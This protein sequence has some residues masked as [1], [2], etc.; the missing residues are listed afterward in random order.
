MV[1]GTTAY[2]SPEQAIGKEL[3]TRTD[4]F[5]LGVIAHE[6]LTGAR[7]FYKGNPAQEMAA[8]YEGE[9]PLPSKANRRV[10]KAV[11]PV[12]MRALE[13]KL[14]KRYQTA[15]EFTRDL[16][17]AAGST[18][19]PKERNAEM[20]RAQFAERQRDT[21]KLLARIPTRGP[22]YPEARTQITRGGSQLF[23]DG[24]MPKTLLA[25]DPLGKQGVQKPPALPEGTDSGPPHSST[26]PSREPVTDTAKA[27]EQRLTA[28]EL[29]EDFDSEETRIISGS[30][31]GLPPVEM[32]TDP[33]RLAA[34]RQPE[35]EATDADSNQVDTEERE[36]AQRRP[37]GSSSASLF[38]AAVLA[39]ILGEIGRASCRERVS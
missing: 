30:K 20:V 7:L 35:S 27:Q 14:D 16:A 25:T 4:L 1:R 13:R 9:I 39:L 10:P 26:D 37:R 8:V 15:L 6:L 38:L 11:D 17:L 28:G 32:P 34:R 3:D 24:P 19:W 18:T 29:F 5:S 36:A 22:S 21:E 12:V 33:R 31:V 23:D 2:M